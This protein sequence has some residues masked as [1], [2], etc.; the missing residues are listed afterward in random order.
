MTSTSLP[1]H[2]PIDVQG[3]DLNIGDWV[4]VV[5]VPLSIRGMPVESLEAFSRAVGNTF[6]IE[7]FDDMGCL[8]LDM[9]PKVSADTIWIEPFCVRRFRRYKRLSKAFQKKLKFKSASIQSRH[10][11]KFDICLREGVNLAEFGATLTALGSDGGFA[12]WPQNRRI[13]GSVYVERSNNRA[14]EILEN[15]RNV[16]LQSQE[17]ELVEFLEIIAIDS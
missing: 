15:A 2:L 8:E 11:L 6:Q 12:V 10:E 4:L 1:K 17:V 13:T 7:A 3:R 14:F 5:A 16:V 9:W